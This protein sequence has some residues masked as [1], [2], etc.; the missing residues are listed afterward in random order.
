[1]YTLEKI[2]KHIIDSVNKQIDTKIS[3]ED[4]VYPPNAEMGDLSLPCFSIAKE[5]GKNPAEVAEELFKK[6]KSD[7]YIS[8][9][10]TAGPYLNFILNKKSLSNDL[11]NN[12]KEKSDNYGTNE[13]G[14]KEKVMIE[15]SNVN[16][17][18]EYHVGHLRNI[19]YG[20]AVSKVLAANGYDAI[21]VSYVNDFGIHVAKTLW[22]FDHYIE[23]NYKGKVENI[24]VD[25]K[26]FVLGKMYVDSTVRAKEDPTAAQ[27]IGGV[28]K[29]IES[30]KGKEY[31]LWQE[32]REWS[33]AQFDKIYKELKVVFKDTMYENEFVENGFKKVQELVEKGILKKSDGAII[34]D[35]EEY[36][37][38]VLVVVRSDGTATYPVADLALASH[39]FEKYNLDKSIYVV[40]VRQALYF[41]QLFKILELMGYKQEMIH[42]GYDFVK[43]PSG[44]MSSRSGNVLTY[45][46]L[47]EEV[48]SKCESETKKRHEDWDD[49]KIKEVAHVVGIGAMKFEMIKTK[50]DNTITFD[51][52]KALSFEGYTAAYI[53]YTF[54]RIQS[55]L[56]K[57]DDVNQETEIDFGNLDELKENN[58]VIK[59]AKYPE[60]VEAA[61]KGYDPSEIAK[62]L[63]ELTK[64]FN[65]YYHS[66]SVLKAED[67]VKLARLA[68]L[69]SVA[70]VIKNGLAI[71]GIE[72]VDEM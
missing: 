1:M 70:Q 46:E 27:M 2:K 66:I 23:E 25:K 17:H 65:D 56:A 28:M 36:N 58:L 61:G 69:K 40:D 9:V 59:L 52:E 15:Y 20:D 19:C 3:I 43:L 18:K 64:L 67:D 13:I 37:L 51:L 68:L 29:Y 57:A 60:A 34:A 32:T 8:S 21:P 5:Q 72:V 50:A 24:P 22:N 48:F 54:A 14:D 45:E 55:V 10:K 47:R 38:G 71:L 42:L 11:I 12:V 26:G 16:T 33:I 39:K 30:R 6:I 62:Y 7:E 31:E 4:L 53:Q 41:K 44:M 35:L 49:E 63:F